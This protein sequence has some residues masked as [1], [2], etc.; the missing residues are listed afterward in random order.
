M[1]LLDTNAIVWLLANHARAKPLLKGGRELVASPAALLE[2]GFLTELGKIRLSVALSDLHEDA[3]FRVDDPS[4]AEWFAKAEEL[5]FTR[6][7]FD[8]LIVAN[9]LVRKAKLATGDR[10][11]IEYLGPSRVLEL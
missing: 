8:R 1:I 7:P 4:G 10:R 5:A 2:V 6:D 3:R 11:I 9:A